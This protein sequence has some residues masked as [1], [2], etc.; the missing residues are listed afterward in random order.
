M[1]S[2]REWRDPRLISP[3]EFF[4]FFCPVC[5]IANRKRTTKKSR[6]F[7]KIFIHFTPI[8]SARVR[9]DSA[10]CF[11]FVFFFHWLRRRLMSPMLLH[12]E[13]IV[14]SNNKSNTRNQQSEKNRRRVWKK[15]AVARDT[16]ASISVSRFR[17]FFSCPLLPPRACSAALVR[18]ARLFLSFEW[19]AIRFFSGLAVF[20]QWLF[21]FECWV[22]F[23]CSLPERDQRL[24][25]F[26]AWNWIFELSIER[27]AKWPIQHT[28]P[29]L[30]DL[31]SYIFNRSSCKQSS[32]T[33]AA[34]WARHTQQS[35][36]VFIRVVVTC[37]LFVQ[38]YV[39]LYVARVVRSLDVVSNLVFT[40]RTRTWMLNS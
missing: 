16:S 39:I 10:F 4:I 18:R 19:F 31:V 6:N 2:H 23:F 24:I 30:T 35:D 15:I 37:S 13:K 38:Y 28:Q 25:I 22:F 40:R 36:A 32:A 11:A 1:L 27:H 5:S 33:T 7:R 20:V 34:S 29:Q 17:F 3:N 12:T 9:A 21:V 14:K 26:T 8:T